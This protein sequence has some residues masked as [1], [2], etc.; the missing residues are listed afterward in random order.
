MGGV[1]EPELYLRWL[2]YGVLSPIMRMHSTN[3]AYHERR[4]WA[5]DAEI[6]RLATRALRLRHALI[7]YLYTAA[8]DNYREGVLPIR[9]MYHLYPD[10][11]DAYLCPDQYYFGSELIAAPFVTPRHEDTRLSRQLVWLPEG[12][13]FDFFTGDYYQGGGWYAIYGDLERAFAFAKAGGIVPLNA[14][15]HKNGVNLPEIFTIKIFLEPTM[16]SPCTKM[17]VR[18]RLIFLEI[19][20]S[21]I[22]NPGGSLKN[23][24]L[25][26]TLLKECRVCFHQC[27]LTTCNFTPLPHQRK[28]WDGS[29]AMKSNWTD[30]MI[31]SAVI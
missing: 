1:E 16:N 30:T 27:E 10:E 15:T 12:H 2:Q 26:S 21:Q 4:P 28:S 9:P 14:E 7:P 18:H 19:T 13:W 17:M 8:W 11:K 24:P 31:S 20:H 22:C 3:S 5:Y 23:S 29:M 25:R 6:E